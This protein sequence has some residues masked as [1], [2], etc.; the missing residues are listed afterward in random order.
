MATLRKVLRW[1]LIGLLALFL[2][3]ILAAVVIA[4]LDVSISVA[5]WRNAIARAAS[6]AIGRD[7][8]L[9]GPLEFVPSLRPA[10]KVGGIHIANPPGFSGSEFAYGPR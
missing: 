9:E 1:T 10:V 5:P 3:P 7:V 6:E 2:L 4:S 8:K